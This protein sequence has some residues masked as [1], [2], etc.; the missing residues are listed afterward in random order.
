MTRE[1]KIEKI[2]TDY[3]AAVAEKCRRSFFFF[4]Q[5]FWDVIINEKP[6]WNWH[7]KF[8]CDELQYVATRVK[9]RLPREYEYYV[10]NVPPG[11]SKSTIISEMYVCWVWT[12]DASQRFICGSFAST[13]SEDIAD[14]C[15]RIFTSDRYKTL[16]PEVG[17]RKDTKTHLQTLKNGERYT[18][19][20]GSGITGIHAHQ[21][22]IDDPLN[23]Q[24]AANEKDR[25]NANIWISETL[26]TRQ[27]DKA[28]TVTILVMQ[29][30]HE[31]DPTGNLLAKKNLKIRHICLPATISDFVRPTECKNYYVNGLMDEVRMTHEI[32]DA[33][34]VKLGS[35]GFAGQF[36]QVPADLKGGIIKRNWLE[37]IDGTWSGKLIRFVLDTAYTE[38]NDNDPSGF[39]SYYKE[40]NCVVITNW[41]SLRLEFPDLTKHTVSFAKNNGYTNKSTVRVEP[42]ASGK[43]LVQQIRKET[44]LNISESINP[45]KDKVTRATAITAKLESGR[46]K[47]LRGAWNEAFL[48][49]VC[50]FPRAKHDEAVDCLVMAVNEELMTPE[51]QKNLSN[52]F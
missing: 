40:N 14:K 39:L 8:L 25:D 29:R 48:T 20:T 18:T 3:N 23:P 41:E 11:S 52:Y 22:I 10:I 45:E 34:K 9:N 36:D 21:I 17:I 33:M 37:V 15:K 26:S 31:N 1:E 24:Q 27:V 19:S 49:E 35:Y 2:T 46:V 4:V 16:F 43:S 30:L 42:K 7:I 51:P 13:V 38:D 28:V 5:T 32:L 44:D 12:I 50:T 6:V 47:L